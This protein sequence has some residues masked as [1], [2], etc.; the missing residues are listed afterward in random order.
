MGIR[1]MHDELPGPVQPAYEE[2]PR[3]KESPKVKVD[4]SNS[5]KKIRA[6]TLQTTLMPDSFIQGTEVSTEVEHNR[7]PKAL[8]RKSNT[9]GKHVVPYISEYQVIIL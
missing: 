2:L 1:C 5:P 7:I 6:A 9:V 8:L 4:K 3:H